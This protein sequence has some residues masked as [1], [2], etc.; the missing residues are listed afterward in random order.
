MKRCERGLTREYKQRA[1]WTRRRVTAKD[2]AGWKADENWDRRAEAAAGVAQ[3]VADIRASRKS[4]E[5]LPRQDRILLRRPHLYQA[6][7]RWV[8]RPPDDESDTKQFDTCGGGHLPKAY[9]VSPEQCFSRH[10]R[11]DFLCRGTTNAR[12]RAWSRT[13]DDL[14]ARH[15]NRT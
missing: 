15:P 8:M 7:A 4:S 6:R 11:S 12:S 10:R 14:R 1:S 2:G 3:R 9:G 13:A 5:K